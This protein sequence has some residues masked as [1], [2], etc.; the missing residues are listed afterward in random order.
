MKSV[1]RIAALAANL[2][3]ALAA[4]VGCTSKQPPESPEPAKAPTI[5]WR[6]PATGY[7]GKI[8]QKTNATP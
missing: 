5:H 1:Y 6:G 7:E 3:A 4:C 2:F 8:D